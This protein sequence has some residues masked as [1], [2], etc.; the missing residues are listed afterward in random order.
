LSSGTGGKRQQIDGGG[1]VTD[2]VVATTPAWPDQL[3]DEVTRRGSR[4]YE[5]QLKADLEREFLGQVVAIHPDS[6][7][8]EVAAREEEA[9]RK[10]RVR[11]P[12]GLLFVRRI[13]PPTPSDLR[14]AARLAGQRRGK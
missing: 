8:H 1:I 13:G 2:A 7:E 10:L 3:L 12:D 5:D 14:L 6:G 4:I 11:Q 9:L